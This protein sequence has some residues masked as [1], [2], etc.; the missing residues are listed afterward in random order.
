[1]FSEPKI[2]MKLST[3]A[4]REQSKCKKISFT[5]IKQNYTFKPCQ[6][7]PGV[8]EGIESKAE[9]TLKGC[10]RVWGDTEKDEGWENESVKG[11][12]LGQ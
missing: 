4:A 9:G 7:I 2:A 5:S 12:A 11:A 3:I 10:G 1:M 6:P 8:T